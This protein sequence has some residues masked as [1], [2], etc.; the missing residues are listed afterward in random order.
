M[1]DYCLKVILKLLKVKKEYLY[2][3]DFEKITDDNDYRV[4][5]SKEK[6]IEIKPYYQ[7]FADR[8]GFISNLSVID[9]LFNEGNN[10][11]NNLQ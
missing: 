8:H 7:V 5:L 11:V 6:D 9:L 4:S 10:S 3:E 2:T 1:N